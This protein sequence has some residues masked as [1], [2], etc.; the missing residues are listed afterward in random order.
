MK[1]QAPLKAEI[2]ISD[3]PLRKAVGYL[4]RCSK[5]K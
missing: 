2:V 3:R 5:F 1:P 4:S